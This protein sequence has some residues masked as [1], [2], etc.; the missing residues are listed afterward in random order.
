ME[1][2]GYL[3]R[4]L[5][6]CP[7]QNEVTGVQRDW[8]Y[9]LLELARALKGLVSLPDIKRPQREKEETE[10]RDSMQ[11]HSQRR[12]PSIT[13]HPAQSAVTYQSGL[14]GQ[15]LESSC[16]SHLNQSPPSLVEHR[17]VGKG[18]QAQRILLSTLLHTG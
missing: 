1:V 7:S 4:C 10:N 11:P 14:G 12:T 5:I 8:K 18:W 13:L 17:F 16:T 6:S 15:L 9:K 2:V 3:L